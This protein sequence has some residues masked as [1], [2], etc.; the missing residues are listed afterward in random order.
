[1]EGLLFLWTKAYLD[2]GPNW[3]LQAGASF[4]T[5]QPEFCLQETGVCMSQS[6]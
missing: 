1:M 5:V 4:S 3:S 6:G 2:S